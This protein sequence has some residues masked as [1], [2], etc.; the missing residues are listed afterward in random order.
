MFYP[1]LS[2]YLEY[3]SLEKCLSKNTISSY[4]G[5]LLS[6]IDFI[7]DNDIETPETIKRNNINGFIRSLRSKGFTASSINRKIVSLKG[8]FSWLQSKEEIIED[9]TI[10]LE[11]PK[12]ERFLPKVLS[13][14]EIDQL[15]NKCNQPEHRAIIELLYSSGLRV[16][17]LINLQL[18]DINFKSGYLVCKGKGDKER[19]IP[20]GKKARYEISYYLESRRNQIVDDQNKNDYIFLTSKGHQISRQEVW[21]LI[22]EL[23]KSIN[24]DIS[25]HTLRHS[26]ATHLL[27]NGADLRVVQELLGH[28]DI[29]TTQVYTHVSKKRLKDVY[30]NIYK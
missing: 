11:Q 22:K 1:L 23:S 9:P 19:L 15:I 13:E 5:D 28:S 17:E 27:E 25:P 26:F 12:L 2:E 6:F 7:K 3:L 21:K 4:S 29:S 30:F 18:N 10:T 20:I 16:S 24:K 8:W 14:K